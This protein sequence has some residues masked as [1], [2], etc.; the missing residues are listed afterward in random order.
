MTKI[1]GGLILKNKI[2]YLF[3]NGELLGDSNFYKNYIEKNSGDIFCGD[4]GFRH[5]RTLK[6]TP[7]EIWGDF[8]SIHPDEVIF[9][10]NSQINLKKFPADKDFTD[11]ELIINYL[12]NIY[13]KIIII[14]GLGGYYAHTLT[15]ISL[16]ARFQNCEFLTD[17]E[18]IFF[19][20]KH[21]L[22]YHSQGQNISFLPL[23]EKV[24]NLTL[25]GFKYDLKNYNL[26]LGESICMSNTI[27]SNSA[28][29]TYSKG[30]LIGILELKN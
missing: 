27:T 11:G 24:D 9:L 2:A 8:D 26:T 25:E 23:S 28:S 22:F 29:V 20:K 21:N 14:G 13:E 30:V 17:K 16:I 12:S 18:K 4:G 7:L 10:E 3:L 19:V 1:M 6:L 5:C 15:N